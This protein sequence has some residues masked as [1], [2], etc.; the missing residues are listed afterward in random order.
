MLSDSVEGV[1]HI[2]DTRLWCWSAKA[3]G[4]RVSSEERAISVSMN[5]EKGLPGGR[6]RGES[7]RAAEEGK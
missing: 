4:Q 3:M 5:D 7:K 6:F 2:P 1:A